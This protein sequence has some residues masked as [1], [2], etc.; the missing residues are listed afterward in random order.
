VSSYLKKYYDI[1]GLPVNASQKQIKKAYFKLAKQ[2]HP[3]VNPSEEAKK[4]FILVNKAYE[5]LSNPDLV[6]RALYRAYSKKKKKKA[7]RKKATTIKRRTTRRASVPKREFVKLTNKQI[8][9]RDLKRILDFFLV[10][11]G[12][13]LLPILI[14]SGVMSDGKHRAYFLLYFFEGLGMA[15]LFAGALMLIP[16]IAVV[17][18]YYKNKR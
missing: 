16:T 3:D 13:F 11:V 9:H 7:T 4:K 14:I 5:V 1:L 18:H 17:V 15:A 8:F 2:Y 10:I 6:R 12:T